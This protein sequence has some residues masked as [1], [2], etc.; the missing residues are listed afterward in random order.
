LL[1]R[2]NAEDGGSQRSP[3]EDEKNGTVIRR[4]INGVKKR[5]QLT[6]RYVHSNKH[7]GS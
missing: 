7:S 1:Q 5:G 4:S 2:R 3:E 6:Y